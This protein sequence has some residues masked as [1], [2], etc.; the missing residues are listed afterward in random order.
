MYVRHIRSAKRCVL[1]ANA[2][3]FPG[4]RL[5]RELRMAAR[6]GVRVRLVL[7][8]TPDRP[9]MRYSMPGAT[10]SS[11]MFQPATTLS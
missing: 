5:L 3:F 7:Q 2:Y 10:D 11:P 9:I 1:I 4:Y 8:G 6:R